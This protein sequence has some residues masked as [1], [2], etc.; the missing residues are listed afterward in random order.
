M[1]LQY[2]D[3]ADRLAVIGAI[4]AAGARATRARPIARVSFEWNEGRNEVRLMLSLWP[5]G[6]THRLATCHPYGDWVDWHG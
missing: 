6:R 2:L 1:V 4:R 5:D 3:P